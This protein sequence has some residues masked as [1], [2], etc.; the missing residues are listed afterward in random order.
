LERE[1]SDEGFPKY[2]SPLGGSAMS[3]ASH[4]ESNKFAGA[5]SVWTELMVRVRVGVRVSVAVCGAVAFSVWTELTSANWLR[6]VATREEC[7][8]SHACKSFKQTGVRSNGPRVQFWDKTRTPYLPCLRPAFSTIVGA[9]EEPIALHAAVA[10]IP[11]CQNDT[12]VE[13]LGQLALAPPMPS[14]L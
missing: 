5:F 8:W 10:I 6:K 12:A 13:Q 9:G 1:W 2:N 4:R 14:V 7:H 11:R 3:A